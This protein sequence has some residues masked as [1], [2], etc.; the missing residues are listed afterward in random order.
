LVLLQID[1]NGFLAA[2]QLSG[3]VM[4]LEAKVG[5]PIVKSLGTGKS[6]YA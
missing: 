1:Q 4:T 5:G 6:S 2:L 3:A